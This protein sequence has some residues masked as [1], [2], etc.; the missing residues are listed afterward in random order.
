M[1]NSR[2]GFSYWN[3]ILLNNHFFSGTLFGDCILPVGRGWN[4]GPAITK[5]LNSKH[6]AA[7][8]IQTK[9]DANPKEMRLL[10]KFKASISI[11]LL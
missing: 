3:L 2:L 11:P 7:V 9:K 8:S 6:T 1:L 10:Q 5:L 4:V